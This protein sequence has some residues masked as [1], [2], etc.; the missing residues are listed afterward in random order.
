VIQDGVITLRAAVGCMT[1]RA[2][3]LALLRILPD[4]AGHTS[5]RGTSSDRIWQTRN[6]RSPAGAAAFW[7][8]PAAPALGRQGSPWPR[9]DSRPEKM[10]QRSG[11]NNVEHGAEGVILVATMTM[12]ESTTGSPRRTC[13]ASD[14]PATRAPLAATCASGNRSCEYRRGRSPA[15]YVRCRAP[16]QKP[17][18]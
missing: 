8:G 5:L 11:G 17:S 6:R 1:G 9:A 12:P 15:G 16:P 7:G 18:S 3:G 14:A 10:M 13:G 2:A 4:H